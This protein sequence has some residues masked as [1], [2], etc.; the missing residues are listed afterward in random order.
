[1][2]RTFGGGM[3]SGDYG[4]FASLRVRHGRSELKDNQMRRTIRATLYGAHKRRGWR[5]RTRLASDASCS[6]R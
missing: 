1:M 3:P 6:I 4:D 5:F 2:D